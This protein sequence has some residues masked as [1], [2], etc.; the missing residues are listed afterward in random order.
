M[1]GIPEE[2]HMCQQAPLFCILRYALRQSGK[3]FKLDKTLTFTPR[4]SVVIPKSEVAKSVWSTNHLKS[5]MAFEGYLILVFVTI[6][7][8]FTISRN[9]KFSTWFWKKNSRIIVNTFLY[10]DIEKPRL[11]TVKS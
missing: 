3:I 8:F 10:C 1:L 2:S 7:Y 6:F 4:K 11:L 9:Y 5:T